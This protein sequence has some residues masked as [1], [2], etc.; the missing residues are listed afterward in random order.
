MSERFLNL[1]SLDEE[2]LLLGQLDRHARLVRSLY[3]VQVA[4]RAGRV[5]LAGPPEATARAEEALGRALRR[6]RDRGPEPGG[7][8]IERLIRGGERPAAEARA[9]AADSGPAGGDGAGGGG[10]GAVRGRSEN[11]DRYLAAMRSH[12]VTFGIGPAGTGKTYL[13]VA[14]AVSLLRSGEYRR[15]ILVRP[16]VEAGE[17]LG[18]LPGD[19]AAKINPYL[20]P[21]YDALNEFLPRGQLKRYMEEEVIEI[22]PLAYMRGR[23]LD[24]AVMILDEG[25]NTTVA[26]MK[27]FLTRLGGRGKAIV[28]GDTTQIDLPPPR[29]SGLVHAA[30]ILRDIPGVTFAHLTKAD[31]VRHPVVQE[32]VRAYAADEDPGGSGEAGA[33]RRGEVPVAMPGPSADEGDV[34]RPPERRVDRRDRVSL[35][36]HGR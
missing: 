21:L 29:R 28:T 32:I 8:E 36:K 5:R 18:F 27:M 31:I 11:Q 26:Q 1:R 6:I 24:H 17:S 22:L 33:A 7:D 25:Q 20:R 12:V 13:A 35:H 30:R 10:S 4:S 9:S 23:T 3:G 16:A 14:T 15:I 34:R 19:I 2:R